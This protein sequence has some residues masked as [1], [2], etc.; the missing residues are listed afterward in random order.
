MPLVLVVFEAWTFDQQFNLPSQKIP[1]AP[2]SR[3]KWGNIRDVDI[4]DIENSEIMILIGANCKSFMRQCDLRFGPPDFP[5]AIDTP[6]GW[7]LCSRTE[8]AGGSEHR[9]GVKFVRAFSQSD[10]SIEDLYH[11]VDRFWS[12]ENFGCRYNFDALISVCR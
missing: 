9:I 8:F 3:L 5:D 10:T 7:S 4:P 12:T 11:L 6:L 2:D 1:R